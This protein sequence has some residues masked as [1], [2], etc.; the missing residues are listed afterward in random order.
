VSDHQQVMASRF[1]A[2][3]LAMLDR[4]AENGSRYV[5]TKHGKPVARLVPLSD[6]DGPLSTD[7]SVT[8]LTEDEE[9]LFSTGEAWDAEATS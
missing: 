8:I 7:G 9:E 5:I 6:E 2:Q 3:C 1:K 4:V